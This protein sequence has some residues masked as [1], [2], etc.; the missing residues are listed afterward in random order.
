M[1][2]VQAKVD[3][4]QQADG[5]GQASA[6]GQR[7]GQEQAEGQGSLL[8]GIIWLLILIFLVWP[9]ASFIAW[10]YILLLPFSACIEPVKDACG[11]MLKVV[12]LPLTCAQNIVARK[13]IT[14]NS[15]FRT[16]LI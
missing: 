5:T 1:E 7:Q 10:F 9:A 15:Y 2:G 8:W 6:E 14:R 11:T 16:D 4:G 12:Q 13:P 3:Q